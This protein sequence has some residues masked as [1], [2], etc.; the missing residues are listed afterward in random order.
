MDNVVPLRS[1]Q[2]GSI[3]TRKI[4][5]AH[6]RRVIAEERITLPSEEVMR[7]AGK[8]DGFITSLADG[9]GRG[10]VTE[11]CKLIWP[12]TTTRRGAD[13]SFAPRRSRRRLW[14]T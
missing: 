9:R 8:I 7:I 1:A 6:F 5:A 12:G 3:D 11:I 4:E 14:T 10:G 13:R 2:T